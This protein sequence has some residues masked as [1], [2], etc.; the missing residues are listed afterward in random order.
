LNI[1][2][3]LDCFKDETFPVPSGITPNGDGKNDVL[4]L[5]ALDACSDI[6]QTM[7]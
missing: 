5:D 4:Y 6:L 3:D 2:D 1:T 7:K